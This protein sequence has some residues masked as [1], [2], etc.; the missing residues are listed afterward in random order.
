[1]YESY[2]A[3]L[4]LTVE[5]KAKLHAIDQNIGQGAG[6]LAKSTETAEQS[7]LMA[8]ISDLAEARARVLGLSEDEISTLN[9]HPLWDPQMVF[10]WALERDLD[11][12]N[13]A[14]TLAVREF[15]RLLRGKMRRFSYHAMYR[16]GPDAPSDK[17]PVI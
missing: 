11:T 3:M 1:M 5:Q 12:L 17:S 15:V 2:E 7:T 13:N 9:G 10:D 6:A 8:A 14:D 16:L 4:P